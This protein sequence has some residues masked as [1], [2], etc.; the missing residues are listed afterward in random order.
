LGITALGAAL[1]YGGLAFYSIEPSPELSSGQIALQKSEDLLSGVSHGGSISGMGC[2]S[3]EE[4]MLSG[5]HSYCLEVLGESPTYD[6]IDDA[7]IKVS[8]S[9][10][11][12]F[13]MYYY[14]LELEVCR[15]LQ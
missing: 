12:S 9:D 1:L 15:E 3:L 2:E 8:F 7:G 13:E 5:S 11:T 10:G 6:H 14:H 4:K